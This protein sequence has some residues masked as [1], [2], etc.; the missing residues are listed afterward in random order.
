[1]TS[2]PMTANDY[3]RGIE[4]RVRIS[5]R[6]I[7]LLEEAILKRVDLLAEGD[8]E[9]CETALTSRIADTFNRMRDAKRIKNRAPF[10]LRGGLKE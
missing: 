5:L 4:S 7:E 8:L 9:K 10:D 3:R 2:K 6:G 1:M